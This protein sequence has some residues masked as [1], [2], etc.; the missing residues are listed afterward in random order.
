[1]AKNDGKI[2]ITIS[3][4]RG[5]KGGPGTNPN[6]SPDG[7]KEKEEKNPLGEYAKH[8]FFSLVKSQA[9]QAVNYSL[10][11][12]GNFTGNYVSQ[13]H[14]QDSK[15][16]LSNFI[17]LGMAFVGGTQA[18]GSPVGG[19][20]AVGIAIA[21][22]TFNTLGQLYTGYIENTKQNN[23]IAQLRTRA[24]LNSTNNGSRGTEY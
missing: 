1:M 17:S 12:I 8:Q 5:G 15:Q 14:V 4:T 19:A 9:T 2:Y 24:G 20:I 13:M 22:Q 23:A 18:T 10:G 7:K 6:I 21:G 11:N 16:V 3:D